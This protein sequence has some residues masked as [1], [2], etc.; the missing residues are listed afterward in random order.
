MLVTTNAPIIE[1]TSSANGRRSKRRKGDFGTKAKTT[2]ERGYTR[3]KEAGALPV[4]ENL[5]GLNKGNTITVASEQFMPPP[6][7]PPPTKEPMST[8]KKVIIGVLIVGAIAGA[9]YYFT[10]VQGKKVIDLKK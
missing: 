5:L 9:Y 3:L 2:A 6:P 8:T 10:K 7:P 1:E 4:I